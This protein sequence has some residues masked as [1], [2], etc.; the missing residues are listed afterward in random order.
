MSHSP[1]HERPVGLRPARAAAWLVA[2]PAL[3]AVLFACSNSGLGGTVGSGD[4]GGGGAGDCPWVGD[5][6]LVSIS[7]GGFPVDN[8]SDDFGTSTLKITQDDAGGCRVD[9]KVT[10]QTC[11]QDE[12]WHFSAPV[13][14][15]VDIES[16]G[17][18]GCQPQAC[19]FPGGAVCTR[20]SGARTITGGY[21][22]DVDGNL[23][24]KEL[25]ADTVPTCTLEV[26]TTWTPKQ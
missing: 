9:A 12:R 13:G 19:E 1:L 2:G 15:L 24:A 25:L 22:A 11:N 4:T 16:E 14:S 20:G 10:D 5:W 7:C 26:I 23:E 3:A 18:I 8:W 17:V 6:E 21:I